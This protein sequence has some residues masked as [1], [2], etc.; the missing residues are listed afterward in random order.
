[1]FRHKIIFI[2]L[3]IFIGG[4]PL[5]LP[6]YIDKESADI[7]HDVPKILDLNFRFQ[8][9]GRFEFSP[10]VSSY[11]GQTIDQTWTAGGR[12]YY[13]FTDPQMALAA[14]VNYQY[15]RIYVG[16]SA[17]FGHGRKNDYFQ[18]INAEMTLSNDLAMRSG[19]SIVE[20]DMF[21]TLGIGTMYINAEWEPFGV[22]GGGVK[23]YPGVDWFALRIDVNNYLHPTPRPPKEPIDCDVAFIFGAPFFFPRAKNGS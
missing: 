18:I 13:N 14:G 21:M 20:L 16:P 6:A 19:K 23:V 9:A 15:G 3:L 11:L 8:K 4:V 22:I 1:M 17:D 2:Y 12:L 5:D 7:K 10:C